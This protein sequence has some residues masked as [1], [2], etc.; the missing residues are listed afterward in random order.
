[1]LRLNRAALDLCCNLHTQCKK[2]RDPQQW[3]EGI[4][5]VVRPDVREVLPQ[6][7]LPDYSPGERPQAQS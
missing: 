6:M 4:E 3:Y 5:K 1:V 7:N 2:R